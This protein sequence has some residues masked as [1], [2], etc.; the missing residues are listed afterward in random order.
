[1]FE[2]LWTFINVK[3]NNRPDEEINPIYSYKFAYL[4]KFQMTRLPKIKTANI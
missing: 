1:M 4:L 2:F 3:T